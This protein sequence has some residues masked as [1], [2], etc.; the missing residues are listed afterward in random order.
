M[1]TLM[2]F[3]VFTLCLAMGFPATAA[4]G[5]KPIP[6][7]ILWVR[8]SFTWPLADTG[9]QLLVWGPGLPVSTAICCTVRDTSTGEVLY[10]EWVVQDCPPVHLY[11]GEITHWARMPAAPGLRSRQ[12]H[13][14]WITGAGLPK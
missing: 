7:K 1:K 6:A 5:R 12:E 9:E 2:W 3:L 13:L 4:P 14:D 8:C 11:S 10:Y